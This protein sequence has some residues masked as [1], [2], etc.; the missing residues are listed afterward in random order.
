MRVLF[1]APPSTGHLLPAL[2]TLQALRAAGHEVLLAAYGG[3]LTVYLGLGLSVVDVG[4]GTALSE[5]Y[6]RHAPG[7]R[8]ASPGRTPEA[9]FAAPALANA[10]LSRRTL[11]SL[12]AVAN[13]WAPDLLMYDPFQGAIPLVSAVTGIPAVEHQ[14][15]IVGGRMLSRLIAGHLRDLYDRH[16]LGAPPRAVSI[17]VVPPSLRESEDHTLSVRGISPHGSAVLPLGMTA[18]G[19]GKRIVISFGTVLGAE[20]RDARLAALSPVLAAADA[21]FLLPA[22][23]DADPRRVGDLPGN[24]RLLP[25]APLIELLRHSDGIIHHGGAGTFMSAVAAGVPQLIVPHAADQYLNAR[26]AEQH[27]FGRH[28][29]SID[30]IDNAV[31]ARL[32]TDDRL[33]AG[34]ARIQAENDLQP[35]P[36]ALVAPLE[37]WSRSGVVER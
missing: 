13:N 9:V 36:S 18:A 31:I 33:R 12:L 34:A 3:D 11:T 30:D 22:A 27:G 10:A 20:A 26:V 24:V 17:E 5:M 7:A 1:S 23:E 4:D 14:S 2:P 19:P 25:W 37:Q 28:V 8:F 32:L 29:A 16:G 6:E 21:E 35:P 15:G